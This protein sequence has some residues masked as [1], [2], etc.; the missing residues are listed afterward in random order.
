MNVYIVTPMT[1]CPVFVFC[2]FE[3]QSLYYQ[4]LSLCFPV[5]LVFIHTLVRETLRSLQLQHKLLLLMPQF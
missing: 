3:F 4:S 1:N 5:T 2:T